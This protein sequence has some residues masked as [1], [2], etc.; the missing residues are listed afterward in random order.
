MN[1]LLDAHQKAEI[2]EC[3][4]AVLQGVASRL[5]AMP[6][7]AFARGDRKGTT[8]AS[9]SPLQATR[10][11]QHQTVIA[12]SSSTAA[13]SGGAHAHAHTQHT[14]GGGD[15]EHAHELASLFDLYKLSVDAAG[16]CVVGMIAPI[17]LFSLSGSS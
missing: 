8:S 10:S 5:E 11:I 14:A 4:L 16:V 15:N 9:P 13:A 1:H 12:A 3:Y 17:S 7:A 6:P 2:V